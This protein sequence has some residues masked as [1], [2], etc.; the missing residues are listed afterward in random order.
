MRLL[1]DGAMVWDGTGAAPFPGK[2][3]IEDE[4][5]AAVAPQSENV[6][7]N[8]AERL[9]AAGKFLDAG[10]GRGPCPPVLRRHAA[11]HVRWAS[12]RRKTMRCSPWT[13]RESFSARASPAP[14]RRAAA[15]VR[16]DVAVRDAIDKGVIDGPR[17]LAASP[18]LTVTGGL[19]DGRRCTCT[20]T[21]SASP[22]TAPTRCGAWRGS[23]C[24]KAST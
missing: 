10:H 1:I 24:A 5:I 4:R 2:V 14:A 6:A 18:E 8:G 22:S 9:D 13:P 16:L 21:A 3:L 12:C 17:L 7:S 19:G 15:K 23:A 11:R 20:R